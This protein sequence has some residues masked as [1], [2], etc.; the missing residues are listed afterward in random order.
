MIY[1]VESSS[2]PSSMSIP[3]MPPSSVCDKRPPGRS[4]WLVTEPS[5]GNRS[6][7]LGPAALLQDS[8]WRWPW[9]GNPRCSWGG[10]R[11]DWSGRS[12]VRAPRSATDCDDLID[13][14]RKARQAHNG[15]Q[16]GDPQRA[17]DAILQVMQSDNPPVHL[18]L[19]SDAPRSVTASNAASATSCTVDITDQERGAPII[20]AIEADISPIDVLIANAGS[21]YRRPVGA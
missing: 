6:I 3:E 17:G 16:P 7:G 1:D 21:A 10:F 8:A 9:P 15:H 12:M 4:S 20:G 13:P 14:I 19:G 5:A 2:L 11:T 18:L